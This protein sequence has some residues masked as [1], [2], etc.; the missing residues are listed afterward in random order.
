VAAFHRFL[1]ADPKTV[2][3]VALLNAP[4]PSVFITHQHFAEEA[5]HARTSMSV[6]ASPPQLIAPI[7]LT[8]A[9]AAHEQL[10]RL[11]FRR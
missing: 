9:I 10:S 11:K 7:V 3:S 5:A 6:A 1:V 8:I 4:R 2:S